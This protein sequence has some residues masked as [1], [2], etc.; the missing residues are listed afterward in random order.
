MLWTQ[1]ECKCGAQQMDDCCCCPTCY[2]P[3]GD[4]S[5]PANGCEDDNGCGLN[6]YMDP[7]IRSPEG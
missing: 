5:I 6:R 2:T 7:S 3:Q 1:A 4:E